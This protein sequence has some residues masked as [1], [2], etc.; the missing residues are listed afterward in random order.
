M[1]TKQPNQSQ[2]STT[3]SVTDRAGARSPPAIAMAELKRWH[4][5]ICGPKVLLRIEGLAVLA[6]A[7]VVYHEI[8]ASWLMFAAL[9]LAPDLF[10][11]V[12]VFG[13]KAGAAV[14][15]IGHTYFVPFLL[16]AFAYLMH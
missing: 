2:V 4:M 11:F 16:W 3:M 15:N 7:C 6:A 13:L 5:N 12:Y 9:F 14:Y 10:M 8:K 1:N